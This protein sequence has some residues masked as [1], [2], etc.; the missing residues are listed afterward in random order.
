MYVGY[1]M[2][3]SDLAMLAFMTGGVYFTLKKLYDKDFSFFSFDTILALACIIIGAIVKQVP[4]LLLP[5]VIILLSNS[6]LQLLILSA[7]SLVFYFVSYQPWTEDAILI[8][9]KFLTSSESTALF[10]F[11]LNGLVIFYGL[12]LSILGYFITIKQRVKNNPILLLYFVVAII[13]TVLISEDYGSFFTQ[14]NVWIMP[15]LAILALNESKYSIFLFGSLVGFFKRALMD[16]SVLIGS[17]ALTFGEPLAKTP[18]HGQILSLYFNEEIV[19]KFLNS[20]FLMNYL[21]LLFFIL[22]QIVKSAPHPWLTKLQEHIHLTLTKAIS[23]FAI[24]FIVTTG[25]EY[26]VFSSFSQLTN[27][28]STQPTETFITKKPLFI[29]IDNNDEHAITG[30]SLRIVNKGLSSYDN[31]MVKATD[32]TTNKDIL[33]SK[34]NDYVLPSNADFFPLLFPHSINAKK[35]RLA[36]YKE[37]GLNS[38][39][40]F[41]DVKSAPPASVFSLKYDAFYKHHAPTMT[42]TNSPIDVN[43]LGRYT[44][45]DAINNL[46]YNLSKKPKFFLVYFGFIIFLLI[47]LLIPFNK[48]RD[49]KK[50]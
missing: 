36:I 9:T 11:H 17:L 28:N 41:K 12:Y 4:L 47:L 32:R 39:A 22:Y 38:I 15:F 31:V 26:L 27:L 2:F 3:Q 6:L 42:F 48:P 49:G 29:N 33:L 18:S 5:F 35:I 37:K 20:I 40:I 19:N 10:G 7:L 23:I 50:I 43:L 13:C 34:T 24:L 44:I 16:T 46:K 30:L 8:K 25:L 14:F 1:V 21:F 45:S